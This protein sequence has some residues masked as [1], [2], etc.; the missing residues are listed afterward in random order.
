MNILQGIE[1][2]HTFCVTLNQTEQIA[3]QK[4]IQKFV[5]HHPVFNHLSLAAQQRRDEICGQNRTHFTG[6]YWHHGFH[7]DGVNSAVI[8]AQRFGISL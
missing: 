2:K 8:V 6:A 7:E 5:Y 3:P 4:I 1:S